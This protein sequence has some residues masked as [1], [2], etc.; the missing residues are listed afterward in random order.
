M[1]NAG[2]SLDDYD[3][4]LDQMD[5]AKNTRLLENYKA[6]KAGQLKDKE[7]MSN[8]AS[9]GCNPSPSNQSSILSRPIIPASEAVSTAASTAQEIPKILIDEQENANTTVQNKTSNFQDA[10]FNLDDE[11]NSDDE[12]DEDEEDDD[13]FDTESYNSDED[14]IQYGEDNVSRTTELTSINSQNSSNASRNRMAKKKDEK[15]RKK[16]SSSKPRARPR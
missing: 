14:A 7:K 2:F 4:E 9:S 1:P 8:L 6:I 3:D 5:N 16:R 15:K 10:F 13:G 12:N 11:N